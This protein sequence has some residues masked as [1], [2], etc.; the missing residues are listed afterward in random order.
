MKT[1]GFRRYVRDCFWHVVHIS[2]A[3]YIRKME[4]KKQKLLAKYQKAH[5]P[6]WSKVPVNYGGTLEIE[7]NEQVAEVAEEMNDDS[8]Q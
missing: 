1:Y 5:M 3:H 4:R 7:G 8:R 6:D 2:P